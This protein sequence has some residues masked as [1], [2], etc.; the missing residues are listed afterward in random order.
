MR[1]KW[2]I[3]M[4]KMADARRKMDEILARVYERKITL[5]IGP[6]YK[7]FMPLLKNEWVPSKLAHSCSLTEW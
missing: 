2:L 1:R 4:G 3:M 5:S 7:T 6:K